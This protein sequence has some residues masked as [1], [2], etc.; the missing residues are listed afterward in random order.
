MIM[1]IFSGSGAQ[2]RI[3]SRIRIW[4]RFWIPDPDLDLQI[5]IEILIRIWIRIR[6]QIR[7]KILDPDLH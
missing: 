1:H 7:T 2:I 5:H 4:I 3:W 6:I